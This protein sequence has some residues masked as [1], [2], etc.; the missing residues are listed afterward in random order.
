MDTNPFGFIF[1]LW[2]K[3]FS[4]IREDDFSSSLIVLLGACYAAFSGVLHN[5][6]RKGLY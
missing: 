1:A 6:L 3:A 2:R 5:L 4:A